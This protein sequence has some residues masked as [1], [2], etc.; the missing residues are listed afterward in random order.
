MTARVR[1]DCHLHTVAS[2]DSVLR[3]ED[4]IARARSAG[5]DVVAVTDHHEIAI[6][7]RLAADRDLRVIVG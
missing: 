1:V 6:A 2:G 5:I 3:A 4:L 7:Q